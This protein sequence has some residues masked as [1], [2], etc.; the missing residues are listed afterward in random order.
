MIMKPI[1]PPPT[2]EENADADGVRV[3]GQADDSADDGESRNLSA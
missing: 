1:S 2:P 3:E